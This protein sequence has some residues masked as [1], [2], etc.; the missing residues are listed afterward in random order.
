MGIQRG[1]NAGFTLAEAAVTIA[2]VAVTLTVLLQSLEGSKLLAAHTRD[3]KIAKELALAHLAEIEAGLWQDELE[4]TRSGS[5]AEQGHGTFWWE[6][7][8]GD[9]SFTD[10]S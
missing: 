6:L 9:E 5:Y 8:I 10:D 1:T 3:Q 7:A 2:L 4:F